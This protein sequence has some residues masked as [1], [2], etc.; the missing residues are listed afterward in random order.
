MDALSEVVVRITLDEREA[1]VWALVL[2]SGG[3][4][5]RIATT[6]TGWELIVAPHDAAP[7]LAALAAY[8]RENPRAPAEA[9]LARG[10]AP[11]SLAGVVVATL[12]L[13]FHMVT[14][15]GMAWAAWRAAGS[16][17]AD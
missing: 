11:D 4:A 3:I 10:A 14:A 7:A 6:A 9:P 2:A 1:D 12:L 16:G 5:H 8:D 17:R 13:G 15:P